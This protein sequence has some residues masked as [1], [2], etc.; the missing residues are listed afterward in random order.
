MGRSKG[1]DFNDTVNDQ[2]ESSTRFVAFDELQEFCE[3]F[4]AG[5]RIQVILKHSVVKHG[6]AGHLLLHQ[7]V[8]HV[9]ETLHDRSTF[10][11]FF[12]EDLF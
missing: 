8:R 6:K 12:L 1:G 11:G 3:I 2:K 5:L 10:A 4:C 7:R 9:E